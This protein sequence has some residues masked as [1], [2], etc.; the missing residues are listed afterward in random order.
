MRSKLLQSIAEHNKLYLGVFEKAFS[1]TSRANAIKAKCLDCCCFQRAEITNC[2][3][4][5]CPLYD[6]RPYQSGQEET[7]ED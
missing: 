7:E 4:P 1:G 2:A 3:V 5:N 6:Y